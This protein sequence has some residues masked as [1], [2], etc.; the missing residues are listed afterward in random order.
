MDTHTE[1]AKQRIAYLA[2]AF[3]LAEEH[4]FSEEIEI[5]RAKKVEVMIYAGFKPGN[6]KQMPHLQRF[7]DETVYVDHLR[8]PVFLRT[9]LVC[10]TDWRKLKDIYSR[11]AKGNEGFRRR[12]KG[13][14]HTWMGVYLSELMKEQNIVHIHAHHG[15]LA[16]WLA[17]VAARML[18]ITY[19]MTLHG[20][21]L[22][23]DRVYLD[24]KINEAS[25]CF[26]ISDYNKRFLLK[27]YP[28][29]APEKV[30][31]IHLGADC[32]CDALMDS[33]TSKENG[34]LVILT[35]GRLASVKNHEFLIEACAELK[36]R[37]HSLLCMIIGEGR[38]KKRLASLIRKLGL[39]Q[40][41]KLLGFVER[42]FL[43]YFHRMADLFVL[44]SKS[45]GLPIVLMEAMLNGNLVLAPRITGIPEIVSDGETGFLYES[46]NLCAFVDKVIHIN[47]RLCSPDMVRKQ[48]RNRIL[49][50]FNRVANM[51][52]FAHILLEKIALYRH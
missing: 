48:A 52:H 33:V 42:N 25:F 12:V 37:G 45:E 46:G 4:Y 19:S 11:L 44:T 26:T 17:M 24:K 6:F 28:V 29:T 14:L 23:I 5:L 9:V 10:V 31:V 8:I 43:P 13:V 40:E 21:D 22:L 41:V 1:H 35:V 27:Q 34:R 2:H 3:P 50:D 7:I 36:R 51:E 18:G 38:E 15:Y 30:V 39:E 47:E 49:K 20:S 32:A 16:S